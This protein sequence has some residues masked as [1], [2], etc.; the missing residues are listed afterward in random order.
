MWIT[1]IDPT[2][3]SNRRTSLQNYIYRDAS[4]LASASV[5]VICH[6]HLQSAHELVIHGV[7]P[8]I[9]AIHLQQIHEVRRA[10]KKSGACVRIT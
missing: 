6:G 1:V 2:K 9:V 5:E 8:L 4:E 3:Y 7:L 10:A